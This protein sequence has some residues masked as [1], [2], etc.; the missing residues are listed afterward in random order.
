MRRMLALGMAAL[1]AGMWAGADGAG[2]AG[3]GTS[4][5]GLEK[6]VSGEETAG[7]QPG[8]GYGGHWGL[9][10]AAVGDEPVRAAAGGVVSFSGTVAG[11]RTVTVDHGGGLKTSYS[12]LARSQV[13][14]GQWVARGQPLGEADGRSHSGLPYPTL[15]FSVRINGTYVDPAP[16]LGC[17]PRSPSAGLRLVPAD[18]T[19]R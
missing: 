17:L 9:D 19:A 12:Y 1:L 4:C 18:R 3:G 14:K 7:Y 15:H 2:G 10:L 16:R 6:P 5:V 8:P 13:A 11:N